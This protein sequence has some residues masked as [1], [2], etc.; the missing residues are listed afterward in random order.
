MEFITADI[1]L[2]AVHDWSNRLEIVSYTVQEGDTIGQLARD[3]G[4]SRD[5]IRWVNNLPSDTIR[6]GK[7]LVIPPGN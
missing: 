1:P 7:T 3:F 4:I 5:T 6:V 2:D